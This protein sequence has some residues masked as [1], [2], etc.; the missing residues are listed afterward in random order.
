MRCLTLAD[1]VGERGAPVRFVGR[2]LSRPLEDLVRGRG[3]EYVTLRGLSHSASESDDALRATEVLAD[4][5]WQWLVVDHYSLGAIWE[6]AMHPSASR[7]LA[8]D[9]LADREHDCDMLLDQNHVAMA[10]ERY[11]DK[12]PKQCRI[13]L[14]PGYALLRPE[15]RA[16]RERLLPRDGSVRRALVFFGG[17]D[18]PNLTSLALDALAH[19]GLAHLPVDVVVGGDE[20]RRAAVEVRAARR[21]GTVIHGPCP[22][23]ADL[24]AGAD[25]AIGGGGSTTWERMCLGLRSLVVTLADN[26]V[27]VADR[28]AND[29]LI[30]LV[31]EA[32]TV[33]VEDL[34]SALL[35]EI[36]HSGASIA[37]ER[38]MALCDGLGASRVV[39]EMERLEA[40][41][42]APQ[43]VSGIPLRS[44]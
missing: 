10:T 32:D 16:A 39:K 34:Q 18:A 5:H 3:H 42:L 7:I 24:M 35:D 38:G 8:I 12:V 31:G 6:R 9:D 26:Q 23:L 19:P 11:S 44:T 15:Y 28:C 17:G 33:S 14:G 29:G 27:P 21:P 30:R 25:I 1:E 2:E 36:A 43:T 13:L 40:A 41:R 22:H 37:L 20:E 4:R